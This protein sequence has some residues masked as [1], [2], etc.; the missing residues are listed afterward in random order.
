MILSDASKASQIPIPLSHHFL[1]GVANDHQFFT[2]VSL[3]YCPAST[4]IN[5]AVAFGSESQD[6][7]ANPE[8]ALRESCFLA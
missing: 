2:P 4:H 8:C 3:Q 1:G 7:P 5:S 6:S